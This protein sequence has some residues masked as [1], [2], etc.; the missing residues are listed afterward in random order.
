MV[1]GEA[2]L[3]PFSPV[4]GDSGTTARWLYDFIAFYSIVKGA[5]RLCRTKGEGMMKA[6]LS[7]RPAPGS[8]AA[9][10]AAATTFFFLVPSCWPRA[11]VTPLWP[12]TMPRR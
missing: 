11:A 4:A 3:A 10:L 5:K 1:V 12:P 6:L 9:P 7:P 2:V 8:S